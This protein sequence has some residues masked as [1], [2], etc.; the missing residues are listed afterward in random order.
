MG[1]AEPSI[2]YSDI[3]RWWADFGNI[4]DDPMFA[5]VGY[6]ADATDPNVVL[7]PDE[8][9]ATWIDG[10]YHLQS[11]AGRWDSTVQAWVQDDVTSPCIDRGYPASP[12]GLEPVPN[13]D[14][15]NMGAYGGTA[16]ASK[17]GAD[18]N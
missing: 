14:I 3:A 9:R 5:N 13:G 6:W 8:P 7:K 11:Q 16:Q 2:T 12:V 1:T 18:T 4:D 15:V 10:D 17:S